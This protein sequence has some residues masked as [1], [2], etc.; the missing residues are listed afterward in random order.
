MCVTIVDSAGRPIC[1]AGV[2]IEDDGRLALILDP[3]DRCALF[4]HYF[5]HG[6]RRVSVASGDVLIPGDLRTAWRDRQRSWWVLPLPAPRA[7]TELHARS[8]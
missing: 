4:E 7:V 3:G 1:Q 5:L 6:E 2:T 8:A